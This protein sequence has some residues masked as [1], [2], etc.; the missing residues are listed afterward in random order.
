MRSS[1]LMITPP[2]TW[3]DAHDLMKGAREGRLIRKARQIRNIGQCVER[4]DQEL[5]GPF[6]P[7]L[8]EPSVSRDPESRLEGPGEVADRKAA[9]LC[10]L[11]EPYSP[12]QILAKQLCRPTFLPGPQAADRDRGRFSQS[13]ILLEQMRPED[14]TQVVQRQRARPAWS[15]DVGKNALGQLSQHQIF[16]VTRELVR[17]HG[18]N[19]K[20][21]RNIVQ[22]LARNVKHYVVK[23][24]SRPATDLRVQINHAGPER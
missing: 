20:I 22:A 9:L 1:A 14:Q 4:V 7:P 11:R 5:L 3:T 13:C 17:P 12:R 15:P 2:P 6:N 24:T 8:H 16:L 23:C 18:A 10:H 19:G 21:G